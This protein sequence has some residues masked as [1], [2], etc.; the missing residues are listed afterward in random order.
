MERP[1]FIFI[2]ADDVGITDL[3]AYSTKLIGASVDEQFYSTPHLNRLAFEGISFEQAYATQ[4]CSPTRA[5]LL[6]GKFAPR[7]GFTTATPPVRT[8]FSAGLEPPDELQPL[9][10]IEH[11]DRPMPEMPLFNGKTQTA[12]PTGHALD[13]GQ[14]VQTIAEAL[15]DYRSAYLGKWHLGGHGAPGHQPRDNGFEELA[16]FDSGGSPYFNWRQNWLDDRPHFESSPVEKIEMGYPGEPTDQEYLTDDLAARA[17][18]FIEDQKDSNRPFLLYF[19]HFAV[20]TPIEA[21]EGETAA[22]AEK[23][24]RGWKGHRNPT[25]AAMLASLDRS[26]GAI[27]KALERTGQTDN[28]YIIFMSDN[29]GVDW[30]V[31]AGATALRIAPGAAFKGE[32]PPTSNAPFRGG[33]A[34]LYE[35]GVRVPLIIVG[36]QA[37]G[38]RW[39]RHP[40]D[41]TDIFPTLYD[42]AGYNPE[43]LYTDA[44][45][46]GRSFASLLG[47]NSHSEYSKDTIYWHYPFNV[48]VPDPTDNVPLGP[49]S[50]IRKG[51][52][53]L[54]VRWHGDK[55]LF[56]IESDPFEKVD[57][58]SANPDLVDKL[59]DDLVTWLSA[60]VSA[61]YF[62][63][64]N[65]AYDSSKNPRG[66]YRT[67]GTLLDDK[68]NELTRRS[69]RS[70]SSLAP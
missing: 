49:A 55:Q 23:P 7:L 32:P 3:N 22:F 62:P 18:Q 13:L 42:L 34:T 33:K 60:N 17:V 54:V 56:D 4:L 19:A 41:A 39:V 47:A 66:D 40:V 43:R 53:K 9:D 57:M 28:T 30:Q 59:F 45:F 35:G 44:T 64:I 48:V 31:G 6:T 36:P 46:D 26:V 16:W 20:H 61:Q 69:K 5:A 51:R 27:R 52:Y 70:Q 1:N 38:G 15:T 8:Y 24:Q 25:Y 50:S 2:L 67:M 68:A 12:L 58:A 37:K 63:K 11:R 29:G 21:P 65:P 14:D 10:A